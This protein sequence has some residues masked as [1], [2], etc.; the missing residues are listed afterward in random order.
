M[1]FIGW[2]NGSS[3]DWLLRPQTVW[4][5]PLVLLHLTELLVVNL[6]FRNTEEE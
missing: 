1:V 6:G 3:R 4:S 2:I 5:T